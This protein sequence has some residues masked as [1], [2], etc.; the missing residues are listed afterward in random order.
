MKIVKKEL[1][2]GIVVTGLQDAFKRKKSFVIPHPHSIK[3][4]I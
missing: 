3:S 1:F 2:A 4:G